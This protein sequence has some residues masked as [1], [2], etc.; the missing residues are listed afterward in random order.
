[1]RQQVKLVWLGLAASLGLLLLPSV[2]AAQT[3]TDTITWTAPTDTALFPITGYRLE[4]SRQPAGPWT[5]LVVTPPTQLM[6][7]RDRLQG[8]E[9]YRAFRL[10]GLINTPESPPS[11]VYCVTR[12]SATVLPPAELGVSSL[13]PLGLVSGTSTGT[14]AVYSRT[15][16]GSRGSRFGT[17]TVGPTTQTAEPFTRVRCSVTDTF[18]FGGIRYSRITDTRVAPE[19]TTGY[20][21]GCVNYGPQ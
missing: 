15:A 2:A 17:L 5:L 13:T 4:T 19:L 21:S 3:V 18:V 14:R 9:C 11:N 7:V 1:M 10:T 6:V 20:V 16:T 12:L 8:Q